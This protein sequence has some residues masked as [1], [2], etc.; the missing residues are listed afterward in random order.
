MRVQRRLI[1]KYAAVKRRCFVNSKD[2]LVDG[3]PVDDSRGCHLAKH[4]QWVEVG[5]YRLQA[6]LVIHRRDGYAEDINRPAMRLYR[7][8]FAF[9][10]YYLVD[11]VF[12]LLRYLCYAYSL[13]PT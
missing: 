5:I 6:H 12:K 7:D 9:A 1:H 13:K 11:S 10:V 8:F 3:L 4:F 2:L